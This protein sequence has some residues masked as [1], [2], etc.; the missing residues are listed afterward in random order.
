MRICLDASAIIY[1]VEGTVERRDA[2]SLAI[3]RAQSTVSPLIATSALSRIECRILPLR[4]KNDAMLARYDMLLNGLIFPDP[5]SDEVLDRATQ[6]RAVHNFKIP[7]AIHLATA[8]V[9]HADVFLTGDR[10][11]VRCPGL[12]VEVIP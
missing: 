8:L 5:I 4:Q 3:A 6:L 11:L 9:H 2:V 12:A 1:L 10:S 7:D